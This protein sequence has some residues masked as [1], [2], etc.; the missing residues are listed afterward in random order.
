MKSIFISLCFLISGV[1]FSQNNTQQF[2]NDFLGIYLGELQIT[3]S[4]GAQKIPMEF[5]LLK[6]DSIHKYEY[7][8]VYDES[9]RNYTLV[10][11]DK[12]KGIFE[13]DE[14]NGIA[15]PAYTNDNVLYSFFEVQGNFL[16]TR[17]DFNKKDELT[18]EILFSKLDKKT[19]TGGTS[20]EIPI[21]YG[22]PITVFQK[23]I[24]K[25]KS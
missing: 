4:K 17:L 25:K 11:I 21:V 13:I 10:V 6:T 22:Y 18:F 1:I 24:L 5:H 15:L 8:L 19:Q 14:N 7:K 23:A 3:T 2:P 12:E 20:K 16:S 9:P